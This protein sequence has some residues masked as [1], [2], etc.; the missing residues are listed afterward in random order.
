MLPNVLEVAGASGSGLD[1]VEVDRQ[2]RSPRCF[3]EVLS[4]SRSNWASGYLYLVCSFVAAVDQ[5]PSPSEAEVK[6][7][8]RGQEAKGPI[9]TH[10]GHKAG[11]FL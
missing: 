4:L 7:G 2:V 10:A 5:K 3:R 6:Q 1:G 8:Y 9:D 11:D